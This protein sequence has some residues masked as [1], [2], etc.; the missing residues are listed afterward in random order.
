[1]DYVEIMRNSTGIKTKSYENPSNFIKS[2]IVQ[3]V[4]EL[5]SMKNTQPSSTLSE[6]LSEIKCKYSVISDNLVS[7]VPSKSNDADSMTITVFYRPKSVSKL[8]AESPHEGKDGTINVTAK[9]LEVLD[10]KFMICNYVHPHTIKSVGTQHSDSDMCHN[11]NNLIT[12]AQM[13]I[14]DLDKD[15]L[16]LQVHGMASKT[17]PNFQML[18]VNIFNAQFTRKYKSGCTMLAMALQ[19]YFNETDQKKFAFA[20]SLNFPNVY[21]RPT[22]AHNTTVQ[23][24]ALNRTYDTGKFIHLELGD[25]IRGKGSRFQPKLMDSLGEMMR[26]WTSTVSASREIAENEETVVD[27]EDETV[28]NDAEQE[29]QID[30][31]CNK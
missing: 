18:V 25:K 29:E 28:G 20:S 4:K 13:A 27:V 31:G 10:F 11:P 9:M 19:K 23:G 8:I 15:F 22:S 1:M 17:D 26:L 24:R 3:I 7:L 14:N 30:S 21:R 12:T 2:K 6:I 5:Y 16:Y